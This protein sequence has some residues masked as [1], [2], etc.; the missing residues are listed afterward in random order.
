M[1]NSLSTEGYNGR[2]IYQEQSYEAKYV[3]ICMLSYTRYLH[4]QG[5][6]ENSLA[7]LMCPLTFF[8]APFS[9]KVVF[10]KLFGITKNIN[11][12]NRK[13]VSNSYSLRFLRS[14]KL[15]HVPFYKGVESLF[16]LYSAQNLQFP[17]SGSLSGSLKK[18]PNRRKCD[19]I[20][21]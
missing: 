6:S 1:H 9:F 14:E 5:W 15:Y 3:C 20:K 11:Y 7:R 2:Y 17:L 19:K 4:K 18:Q 21:K 8:Q 12:K 10:S 16:F 13:K